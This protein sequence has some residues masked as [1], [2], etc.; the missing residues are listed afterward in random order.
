MGTHTAISGLKLVGQQNKPIVLRSIDGRVHGSL[1]LQN[2]SDAKITLKSMP[3]EAEKM[4]SAAH[5]PLSEARMFGRLYPRQ[6]G[7][8]RF[9]IPIDPATPPGTYEASVKIG[10]GIQ[11]V[12]I[13]ITEHIELEV[14]PDVV[15]LKVAKN[16][17]FSQ[18]FT[19][20]NAGNVPVSLGGDW[21][22]TLASQ[23]GIGSDLISLLR[24]ACGSAGKPGDEKGKG[25]AGTDRTIS[26]FLCGV[27]DM[28]PG[29]AILSFEEK[30]IP[31][32]E[33]V[34]VNAKITLPD[35][36][37]KNMHYNMDIDLY[38]A[39]I[40]VDIYTRI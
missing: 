26:E 28:Y 4:L 23:Q 36:L 3:I 22:L 20:Y 5:A 16:H 15:L 13:Q 21:P 29:T 6:K 35:N 12:Q 31:P 14:E 17:H 34:T 38:S 27:A 2:E 1:Q 24:A 19:F 18:E 37:Q 11:P 8:V 7:T 10:E 33:S 30:G 39:N 32:G 9:E 40:H 25:G